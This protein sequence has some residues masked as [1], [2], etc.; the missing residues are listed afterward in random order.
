MN[1]KPF[2]NSYHFKNVIAIQLGR[3]ECKMKR[4][5]ALRQPKSHFRIFDWVDVKEL[6]L[7]PILDDNSVHRKPAMCALGRLIRGE[8]DDF[9]ADTLPSIV[10]L[11]IRVMASLSDPCP[12]FSRRCPTN[13]NYPINWYCI[14]VLGIE[15]ASLECVPSGFHRISE[16]A[17]VQ[18]SLNHNLGKKMSRRPGNCLFLARRD[19]MQS[20]SS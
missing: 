10:P 14:A 1:A 2:Q 18:N 19:G 7:P 20:S 16:F 4:N 6:I 3:S 11:L 15:L 5:A 17:L 9:E 13:A 12:V 8:C